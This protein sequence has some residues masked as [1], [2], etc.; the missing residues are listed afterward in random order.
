MISCTRWP[1]DD[2]EFILNAAAE[3]GV[4]LRYGIFCLA[5]DM[6]DAFKTEVNGK[7]KRD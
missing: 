7:D 1:S 6:Y 2:D 5:C 3:R 4:S